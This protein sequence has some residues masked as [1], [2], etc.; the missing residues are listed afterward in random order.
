MRAAPPARS[1]TLAPPLLHTPLYRA[2]QC[3]LT[4]PW[5]HAYSHTPQAADFQA[6]AQTPQPRASPAQVRCHLFPTWMLV[7][8]SLL[9]GPLLLK[10]WKV[11]KVFEP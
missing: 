5:P 8:V 10:T 11:C 1:Q 2:L 4:R 6:A 7:A 9:Y 3:S